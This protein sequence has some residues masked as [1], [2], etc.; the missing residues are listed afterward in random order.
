MYNSQTAS[1]YCVTSYLRQGQHLV[2]SVCLSVYR[3]I[4]RSYKFFAKHGWDR[5]WG[6][7][8][9]TRFPGAIW[10]WIQEFFHYL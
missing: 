9:S 7:K 6:K 8:Q 4:T 1:I 10:I 3:Q 2:A 5:V